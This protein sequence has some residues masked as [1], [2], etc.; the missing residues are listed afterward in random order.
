MKPEGSGAG[1]IPPFS[2]LIFRYCMFWRGTAWRSLK[3]KQQTHLHKEKGVPQIF[4]QA[5]TGTYL[6]LV[7]ETQH[8]SDAFR[9]RVSLCVF[10]RST[11]QQERLLSSASFSWDHR[12][13]DNAT[14]NGG[15]VQG[16]C[17]RC[18]SCLLGR[19]VPSRGRTQGCFAALC[20]DAL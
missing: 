19:D 10:P 20:L 16:G 12:S 3:Q 7:G 15:A 1:S 2:F 17:V 6:S 9:A 11:R 4:T 13:S 14:C 8:C 5:G 18:F